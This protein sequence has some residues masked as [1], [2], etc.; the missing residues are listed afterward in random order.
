MR[1]PRRKESKFI[2][3]RSAIRGALLVQEDG[4]EEYIAMD[5]VDTD[6][7]ARLRH[8]FPQRF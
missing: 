8:L 1:G 5:T 4:R 2:P 3:L 7:F 6:M